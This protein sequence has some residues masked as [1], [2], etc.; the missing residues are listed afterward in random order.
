MYSVQVG[1]SHGAY[2]FKGDAKL[3]FDRLA[4]ITEK[5]ENAGF[6][7]YPIVL[8]GASSVDPDVIALCNKYGGDI[9]GAKGI[10]Y[11]MLR[12]A[13]SM[14]VCKINMTAA[15]REFMAENPDK[16]DPRGYLGAARE[17]IQALVENKIKN[18]L[19]SENSMN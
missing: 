18:V 14:A 13:S 9:K 12:K 8:H 1:T 7:N 17:K 11:D 5:L 19:G 10:P 4:V 3:D 6:K 16:F 15:V 2:K